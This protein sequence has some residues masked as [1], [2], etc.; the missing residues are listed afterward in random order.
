M[1]RSRRSS[2]NSARRGLCNFCC[3]LLALL[4]ILCGCSVCGTFTYCKTNLAVSIPEILKKEYKT[5]SVARLVGQTLWVYLPVENMIEAP[6]KPQKYIEKFDVKRNRSRFVGPILRSE[7]YVKPVPAREKIQETA[8]SKQAMDTISNAWKVI[9]RVVFSMH[10][11]EREEVKF[12]VL[13]ISDIKL[14]YEIR[15]YFYYQD[16]SKVSYGLISVGEY[17]HR[18]VQE[19]GGGKGIVGDVLGTHLEYTDMTL[20]DFVTRQIQH[21][22]GLKFQ[23]PEVEPGIDIDKEMQKVV[24]DTLRIYGI[25]DFERA[26]LNNLVSQQRSLLENR[27]V[28]R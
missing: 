6:E 3:G 18:V 14:G 26:E 24:A 28:W 22:V 5:D 15:E 13:V 23:K 11:R 17:Q 10:P 1:T 2:R 8:I 21:R 16:L 20:R 27:D 19:S 4:V 12:F 7:F 9:R 25:K